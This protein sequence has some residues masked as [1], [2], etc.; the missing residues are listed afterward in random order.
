MSE[1]I[2]IYKRALE[3]EKKAKLEAEQILEKKSKEL[4]LIYE[5]LKSSNDLLSS[6]LRHTTLELNGLFNKLIEAYIL[7]EIDGTIIKMNQTAKELFGWNLDNKKININ[8]LIDE[9]NEVTS[10][11]FV[12]KLIEKG[13]FNN[14]QTPLKTKNGVKDVATKI[15]VIKNQ[16]GKAVAFHA[17]LRDVTQEILNQRKIDEQQQ[18]LKTI[19]ENSNLG[20]VLT[21]NGKIIQ[22]NKAIEKLLGYTKGE[23][24]NKK[25]KDISFDQDYYSFIEKTEEIVFNKNDDFS[26]N[27]RYLKKNQSILWARS[28]VT[29][30][31][32]LDNKLL[33]QII[34]IENITNQIKLEKER[35]Q[36]IDSLE[37]KNNDLNDYAHVVSH[38]LKSPLSGMDT[39]VNWL[40]EDHG[41]ELSE[42]G[43]EIL[44]M[45]L[46]KISKMSAIV[47]GILEYSSIG[48]S[49]VVKKDIE[50][51]PLIDEILDSIDKPNHVIVKINKPLPIVNGDKTRFRQIF[52]NL[53]TNA[54][55]AIGEKKGHITIGASEKDQF[56]E[57]YVK[58]NGIGIANEY[59]KK[60]FKIF[61]SLD[62]TN[63]TKG[64]GLSIVK[65][66]VMFYGGKIWFTSQLK[67][68]TTFYFTIENGRRNA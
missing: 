22:S 66:I 57:F 21:K 7:T 27:K 40:K 5:K 28:N 61:E 34:I 58:D 39:L 9:S 30:I 11:E 37:Q 44:E 12:Q 17:I 19:F 10:R 43:L 26:I 33:H 62:N 45:L 3:R 55:N 36:L 16:A 38:D 52:Q 32:D 18:Q 20:I 47:E 41:E 2:S 59:A 31:R 56:I 53:I 23:L 50:V 64:V 15:N 54:I 51:E 6:N 68:G 24:K 65:K 46:F 25:F 67:K 63:Y 48:K 29:S 42:K 8:N 1:E 13:S 60:I 35:D 4:Y 14:F 49:N